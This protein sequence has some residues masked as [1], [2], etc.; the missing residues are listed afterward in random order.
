MKH[1]LLV[2]FLALAGC[3]GN[4]NKVSEADLKNAADALNSA[5]NESVSAKINAIDATNPLAAT[6]APPSK[7]ES[8]AK[9]DAR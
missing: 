1:L 9:H 8:S 6:S 4:A 5:T 2:G 3:G 7:G